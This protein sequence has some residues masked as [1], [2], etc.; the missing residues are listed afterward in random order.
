M[1][2]S[3][4]EYASKT[5][6]YEMTI[7]LTNRVMIAIGI[8]NFGVENYCR[9]FYEERDILWA[10]KLQPFF[11]LK[12]TRDLSHKIQRDNDSKKRR[13]MNNKNKLKI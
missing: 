12:I 10:P 6:T 9:R 5:K 4:T 1:T 8:S 11:S 2:S 13:V 3:I 7:S